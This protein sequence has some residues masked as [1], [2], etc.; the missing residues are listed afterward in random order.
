MNAN[1]NIWIKRLLSSVVGGGSSWFDILLE[2]FIFILQ[3]R[4]SSEKSGE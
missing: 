2:W 1:K 4:A 3:E